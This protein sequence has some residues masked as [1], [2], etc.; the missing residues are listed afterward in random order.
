MQPYRK[1]DEGD[2]DPVGIR[3]FNVKLRV[4]AQRLETLRGRRMATAQHAGRIAPRDGAAGRPRQA[5]HG[6]AAA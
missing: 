1:P 2:P 5:M 3:N 6:S 4:A